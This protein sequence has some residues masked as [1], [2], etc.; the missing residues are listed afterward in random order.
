MAAAASRNA[1]FIITGLMINLRDPSAPVI[2]DETLRVFLHCPE[3]AVN[4]IEA[5][6]GIGA[7][8]YTTDE[9]GPSGLD[10]RRAA[11]G[12]SIG[13]PAWVKGADVLVCLGSGKGCHH[14]AVSIHHE[15]GHVV[16]IGMACRSVVN[17][18]MSDVG[19]WGPS[20]VKLRF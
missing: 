14:V 15:R 4:W 16:V 11:G 18:A 19:Q 7:P 8:L 2:A 1:L 17:A 3:A 6:V 13:K 9:V 10:K 20:G 5:S 12:R